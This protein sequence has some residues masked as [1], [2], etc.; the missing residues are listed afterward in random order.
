MK[1]ELKGVGPLRDAEIGLDGLTVILGQ[2][3]SGKST[4]L[5]SLYCLGDAPLH[6]ET[7]K[8]S[9]VQNTVENLLL[10][11]KRKGISS[12][13]DVLSTSRRINDLIAPATWIQPYPSSGGYF[14]TA[15]APG[16]TTR[17]SSRPSSASSTVKRTTTS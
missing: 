11:H 4:I 1:L 5:R 13:N 9:D 14:R 17:K 16:R 7:K 12:F 10:R 3:G 8:L 2:N 15:M 6:F